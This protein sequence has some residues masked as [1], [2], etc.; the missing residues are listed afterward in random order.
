MPESDEIYS[1]K[2][3]YRGVFNFAEFYKFCYDWL[4]DETDLDF[5]LE[6]KYSEKIDGNSKN[7]DVEWDGFKKITDFFKFKF[8]IKFKIIKLE[9]VEI[10]QGGIKTSTNKGTAEIKVK[11]TLIR[12]YEGKFERNAF[13]VFLRNIYEKWII[14]S[15]IDAM[16]TKLFISCETFLEQAKAFLDLEGRM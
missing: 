2:T 11:G 9:K 10:N 4:V 3:T 15:R 14:P 7:I 1:N 16:E 13:Q 5:V 6:K 12:D 8:N